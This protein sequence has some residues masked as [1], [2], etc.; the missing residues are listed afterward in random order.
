MA[1]T[2]GSVTVD[3]IETMAP[4][5]RPHRVKQTIGKRVAMHNVIHTAGDDNILDIR[6]RLKRS[7][8]A[9]LKTAQVALA[10]VNDGAKHTF[11]DSSDTTYDG[12]YVIETGS[13]KFERQINPLN[14]KFSLRLVE[15]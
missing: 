7:T 1:V 2:F 12:N 14:V 4:S 10:A 8:A 15:W 13:L 6:G 9:L 11:A 3:V 5:F